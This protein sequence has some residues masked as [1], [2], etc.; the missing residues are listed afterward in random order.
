M[1]NLRW[2]QQVVTRQTEHGVMMARYRRAQAAEAAA[3]HA[4]QDA[5]DAYIAALERQTAL[6]VAAPSRETV[7]AYRETEKQKALKEAAEAVKAEKTRGT[8]R[9]GY[10]AYQRDVGQPTGQRYYMKGR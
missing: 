8:N 4:V 3:E 7:A 9:A 5:H 10:A 1:N 6:H 2:D